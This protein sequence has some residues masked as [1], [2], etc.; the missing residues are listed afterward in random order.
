MLLSL[1]RLILGDPGLQLGSPRSVKWPR[2]RA[3]HLALHPFCEVCG[4]GKELNVHHIKPYHLYPLLELESSNLFTLGENC[5]TGN[6]H[7][8]F[9]HL[10][11]WKSYNTT[12][13]VDAKYWREKIRLRVI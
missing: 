5:P 13:V 1:K 4:Y 12:V 6:H 8:L 7:L 10:G 2:V 9:G 3:E 11:N